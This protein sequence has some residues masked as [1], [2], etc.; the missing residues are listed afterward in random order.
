MVG[1]GQRRRG[2]EVVAFDVTGRDFE[3]QD[4]LVEGI[5]GEAKVAFRE[6]LDRYRSWSERGGK[7]VK[8]RRGLHV[9]Y[10]AKERQVVARLQQAKVVEDRFGGDLGL[11]EAEVIPD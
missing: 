7:G 5:G 11:R 6:R 10:A 3:V 4:G 2:V 9:G 8:Q 1:A